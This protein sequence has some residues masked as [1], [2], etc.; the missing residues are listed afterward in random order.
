MTVKELK[1]RLNRMPD[2]ALVVFHNTYVY[3]EGFYEADHIHKMSDHV[4]EISSE[5]NV[6]LRIGDK[7]NDKG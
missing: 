1:R 3:I 4:V 6:K 5:Y 2:D 7:Y